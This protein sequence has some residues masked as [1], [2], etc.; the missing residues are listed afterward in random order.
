MTYE[1]ALEFIYGFLKFA[2]KR[3]GLN[4][5]LKFLDILKNPQNSLKFIH[6]A[7]TN[8]KGSVATYCATVL[9]TCG[10]KV[11]LFTSPY[12]VCF[13]ERIKI[14]GRFILKKE[15]KELVFSLK[16]IAKRLKKEGVFLTQFDFIT[17]IAFVYFYKKK[18]DFVVLEVGLGG[19]LDSTNVVLKPV[20]SIITRID[21]DHVK[22]LKA[23][24]GELI[25]NI[26]N[27]KAGIVKKKGLV[28]CS[29]NQYLKVLKFLK[30]Q[31]KL[32]KAKLIFSYKILNFKCTLNYNHFYFNKMKFKTRL[33]GPFQIENAAIC[34]TA[35][36]KIGISL[37]NIKK[38]LALAFIPARFEVF[39]LKPLVVLDGAHN[40]NGV[41]CLK[42]SLNY[43][44][45]FKT[46]LV[47]VYASL[48]SKDFKRVMFKFKDVFKRVVLTQGED[49]DF[50]KTSV[51]KREA[52][53]LKIKSICK[54]NPLKALEKAMELAGDCGVVVVFGS[55]K[56]ASFVRKFLVEKVKK[57]KLN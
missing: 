10:F 23:K 17:I 22:E 55:L 3:D 53:M 11:G 2:S 6:I 15:L 7:G 9:K 40:E 39:K 48:K 47:G 12:V 43:L 20:V 46:N 30:E 51:L 26:A 56:L 16:P 4:G 45:G 32:K 36:L 34:L 29:C 1:K 35:L 28:V 21:Y 52:K 13:N 38:G 37:K 18:C 14:N 50:L 44:F 42:Q 25:L 41:F 19:R 49:E 27:E 31:A 8:G 5:I 57:Q 54:N 33:L 24:T